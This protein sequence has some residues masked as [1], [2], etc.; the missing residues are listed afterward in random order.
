[1]CQCFFKVFVLLKF[2]KVK[3]KPYDIIIKEPEVCRVTS[4][5]VSFFGYYELITK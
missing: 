1:M 5:I 2:I 4:N 3:K